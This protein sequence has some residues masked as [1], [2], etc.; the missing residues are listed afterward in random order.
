MKVVFTASLITICLLS[1]CVK[2]FFAPEV[3]Q[4]SQQDAQTYVDSLVFVKHKNGLCFGVTTYNKMSTNI[5]QSTSIIVT[6]VPC[7]KVGL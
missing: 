1:G 4:T 5:S 3:T 6:N 2:D 7:E